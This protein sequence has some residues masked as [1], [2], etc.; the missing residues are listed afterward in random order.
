MVRHCRTKIVATIG[1]ASRSQKMIEAF[2][3]RGVDVFRIN[4]SHGTHEDHAHSVNLI[5]AAEEKAGVSVAILADL[6][7]PKLRIGRFEGGTIVLE[8]GQTFYL[9]TRE[10]LGTQQR[11]PFP[12]DDL[13]PSIRAG[14]SL[15]LDDGKIKVRVLSASATQLETEVIVGGKLSNNKGVNIPDSPLKISALTEKD[16]KDLAFVE[17]LEIDYVALSFVQ[18]AKDIQDLKNKRTR[19]LKIV[20]KIEKPQAL[21]DMAAILEETDAIM[22]ARGDLGVEMDLDQVPL[23]QKDLIAQAR[24]KGVPVIVATHM[25]ESMISAPT[26]TRAEVSDVANAVL[27]GADAV[28]LSAESAAGDYPLEAVNIMAQVIE[29]IEVTPLPKGAEFFVETE[30]KTTSDAIAHAASFLADSIGAK[31]LVCTTMTGSTA[32]RASHA[33]GRTHLL[34]LT[35]SKETAR[36]LALVWGV[37]PQKIPEDLSFD[38]MSHT[39]K[40]LCFQKNLIAPG[41]KIVVTGSNPVGKMGQTRLIKVLDIE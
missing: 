27:D 3:Q 7:G 13:Y 28:M 36:A 29:R 39:V 11:V 10:E 40:E 16:T 4:F 2:I 31:A 14:D 12:H 25:L 15:L 24:S 30:R 41:D 20:A 33:R 6:Q 38:A 21:Q 26:P 18:S 32:V 9:D 37:D 23:I 35:P 34:A 22:V 19:P 17:T 5:R 1:P 8:A